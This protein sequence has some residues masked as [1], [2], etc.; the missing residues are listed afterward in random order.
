MASPARSG[1]PIGSHLAVASITA[2][3]D[4]ASLV[5]WAAGFQNPDRTPVTDDDVLE[6][7]EARTKRRFQRNVLARARGRLERDG[8]LERCPSVIGRTGRPTVAFRLSPAPGQ[9]RL[10]LA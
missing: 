5:L 1:D 7:V 9:L 10:V 4:L 3:A 6:L 8:L 2:D